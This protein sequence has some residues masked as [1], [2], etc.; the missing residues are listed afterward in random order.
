MR[1]SEAV[2][3]R[4]PEQSEAVFFSL[5]QQ[6]TTCLTQLIERLQAK[7]RAIINNQPALLEAE[8]KPVKQLTLT[9]RQLE[10]ERSLALE[11]ISLSST[12]SWKA[13]YGQLSATLS[14]AQQ[15]AWEQAL[16][17]LSVV[18][19][20]FLHHQQQVQGLLSNGL[21]WIEASIQN[22]HQQQL[23]APAGQAYTRSGKA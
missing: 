17:R 1:T 21:G 4:T 15:Q 6:Q 2:V 11:A 7:S 14:P 19:H 23:Q 5:L 12:L 3:R 22:V 8:L 13:L 16:S 9:L 20:L 18:L 10:R